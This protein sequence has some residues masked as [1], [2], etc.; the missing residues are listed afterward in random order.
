[1]AAGTPVVQPRHGGFEE[2]LQQTNGGVLSDP[3]DFN[4]YIKA[5]AELLA[6]PAEARRLGIAGRE[7]VQEYFTVERMARDV[8][9]VLE[10]VQKR[11][12]EH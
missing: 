5:L 7:K 4:S 1:M 2:I 11:S 10:S 3:A 8:V 12:P 6:N 9:Q